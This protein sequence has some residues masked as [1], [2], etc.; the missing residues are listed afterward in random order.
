MQLTLQEL[1][2]YAPEL[3]SRPWFAVQVRARA[4]SWVV[5]ILREKKYPCLLPTYPERKKYSD[6]VKYV[7]SALFPG[8]VF[9]RFDPRVRLPILNT[10]GVTSI[11][12]LG[13]YPQPVSE[14]DIRGI[15]RIMNSGILAK[16]WPYMKVGQRVRIGDGPLTGVEG[17]L[18]RE[19]GKDRLVVSVHLLQRSVSVEIDRHSARPL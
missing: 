13:R 2:L 15:E 1:S 14:A 11:V 19:R 6:R 3:E 9:C 5:Q 16:P 12:T 4:E 18:T 17:L 8:Y 10:P 7:Q